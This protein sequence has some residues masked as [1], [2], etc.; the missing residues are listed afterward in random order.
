MLTRTIAIQGHS[1]ELVES[2]G[3]GEPLIVLHGNSSAADSFAGLLASPLG[4]ARKLVSISLPGHGGSSGLSQGS[5][6]I[7]IEDIGRIAASIVKELD[8]ARYWLLGASLGGHAILEALPAFSGARGLALVSAPP[9]SLE[10]AGAAFAPD[11]SGGLLFK[12][13]LDER[14]QERLAR[15]FV[16]HP[17]AASLGLIMRNIRRTDERFRP[18]LAASLARG[19]IRDELHSLMLADMPVALLAGDH[20]QFLRAE[21]YESLPKTRFWRGAVIWFENSGHTLNLDCPS[22]FEQTIAQFMA[23]N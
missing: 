8:Y 15:C 20:D 7:S 3:S 6:D 12:G 23:S 2:S 18:A 11:P 5:D 16:H 21:F 13:A 4:A 14:E 19:A 9:I 22:L 10:R 1:I 17:T